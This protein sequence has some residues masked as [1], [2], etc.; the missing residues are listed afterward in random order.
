MAL[1]ALLAAFMML[2]ILATGV[3]SV[4]PATGEAARPAGPSQPMAGADMQAPGHRTTL[5]RSRAGSQ[6]GKASRLRH[7]GRRS[8]R[9]EE[10]HQTAEAIG[11]PDLEKGAPS[12]PRFF[13]RKI[14][15]D[16]GADAD[17]D[18][19]HAPVK[20]CRPRAPPT[21]A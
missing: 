16:D 10:I 8:P 9:F 15:S 20:G 14:P 7:A 19:A 18:P 12:A 2:A 3:F 5:T 1:R 6:V 13:F 17:A 4:R 11:W 21:L